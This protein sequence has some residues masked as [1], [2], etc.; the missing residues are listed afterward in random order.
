MK[1]KIYILY[2][3]ILD[4]SLHPHEKKSLLNQNL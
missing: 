2:N 3:K 4:S 1:F